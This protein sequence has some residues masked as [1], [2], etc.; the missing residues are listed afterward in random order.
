MGT[1][2]MR[3]RGPYRAARV[4][5]SA[6]PSM[7]APAYSRS[8]RRLNRRRP[9]AA[10]PATAAKATTPVHSPT[11]GTKRPMASR[12][13]ASRNRVIAAATGVSWKR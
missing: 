11:R 1:P 10:Y 9:N 2:C 8:M 4:I 3:V 7:H 5:H 13:R 6:T 12:A